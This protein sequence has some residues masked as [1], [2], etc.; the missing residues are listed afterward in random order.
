[1]KTILG[2]GAHYDDCVFGIPGILL[3]AVRKN[4]RVVVLSLIGDYENWTPVRGRG[5]ELVEKTTELGKEYGVEHQFLSFASMQFDVSEQTKRAVADAVAR[6]RPDIAFMLWPNDQHTDHVV[7]SQLSKL[8]L[9]HG[10]RLLPAGRAFKAPGRIYL[11]DNGPRHTI[12]FEP[13]TYV[14]ISDDWD[15]AI[16][17]LGR[18]MAVVRNGPYVPGDLDGAQRA[19]E[20][21]A[22]YRGAAC[23]VKYSEALCSA[24]AYPQD[25]L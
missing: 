24:V 25:V 4:Y 22:R 13:N 1:M 2:I 16:E 17:W 6:I 5:A 18:L 23:G 9:R 21:I 20:A 3:H 14:D 10:D 12:G 8:A 15:R 11:Y 7:A 19:K